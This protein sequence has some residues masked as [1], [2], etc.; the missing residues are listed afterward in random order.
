[1]HQGLADKRHAYLDFLRI[2]AALLVIV[3]HTNSLVFK[4]LTPANA[5]WWLS[6]AWY[7]IS[8]IAVPLFV[9][10]SGACLL[11]KR[12]SYQRA[13]GRFVRVLLTLVLFSY[14]YYLIRLMNQGFS[15]ALAADIPQFL[16]SIWR[17]RIT[18]S[19]WYL[20]FYLGMMVMLPILQRLAS[21]MQKQDVRYLL[22]V[23]FAVGALWP[24]LTHYLP[25][26]ALP[27]YT[28]IP[29]FS[30]FIGLFFAGHYVHAMATPPSRTVCMLALLG[31]LAASVW[32]TYVE[33]GR[34]A[35]GAKY[36]FMDERTQPSIFIV[37]SSIVTMLWAKA[38]FAKRSQRS[39]SS[40]R[41]WATL[42]GC[43]FGIYL[44]QDLLIAES[45]YRLFLPLSS[46]MN[47]FAAALVWEACVFLAALAL[48]WVLK[49]I[50]LLKTL[51]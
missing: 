29:M 28:A 35:D 42:G 19:F 47:P 34:V 20:Y 40:G 23:T 30:V 13:L 48:A 38:G 31:S 11:P 7:Y 16:L 25:I 21:A 2:L 15:W 8:K 43:A 50:P 9:M 51:L 12:D 24:L 1:M 44:L 45:R 18:D 14:L 10:V 33:V 46:I 5:T 49:K 26:L 37:V 17:G 41:R 36:W 6:I 32:L 4:A 27:E 22:L 3:N 39:E